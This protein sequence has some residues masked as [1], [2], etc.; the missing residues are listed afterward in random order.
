MPDRLLHQGAQPGLVAVVGTFGIGA[1][2]FGSPVADLGVP[3]LPLLGQPP[4]AAVDQ[5]MH[6]VAS[7][8]TA[9]AS[10]V[11]AISTR[12]SVKSVRLVTKVPSGWQIPR[13][14]SAPSSR[15]RLSPTSVLEIPTMRSAR[16]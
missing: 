5:G 7:P 9:A 2:I 1:L 16:R 4:K 8:S 6:S 10:P 12:R 11:A 3:A 15:F 13:A 14:A